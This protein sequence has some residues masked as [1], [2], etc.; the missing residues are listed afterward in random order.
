MPKPPKRKTKSK[1]KA[2]LVRVSR[3]VTITL[4][5]SLRVEAATKEQAAKLARERFEDPDPGS[6]GC[7]IDVYDTDVVMEQIYETIRRNDFTG[8]VKVDGVDESSF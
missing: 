1:K 2:F 3:D 5:S 4:T 7:E 6:I 8:E